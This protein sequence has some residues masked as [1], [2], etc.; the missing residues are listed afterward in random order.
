M[1]LTTYQIITNSSNDEILERL[2]KAT[3]E[4]QPFIKPKGI[5]FLGHINNK[6]FKL[7][8]FHAPPMEFEFKVL[9]DQIHFTYKKESLVPALKGII[10]GLL[11]PLFSGLMLYALISEDFNW[12]GR[13]SLGLVLAIVFISCVIYPLLYKKFVLPNDKKFLSD[14]KET[15]QADIQEAQQLT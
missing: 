14:L 5:K 6:S 12:V 4:N 11:I 1:P 10:Y 7:V 9:S 13:L 15:L 8:T 3:I 2:K